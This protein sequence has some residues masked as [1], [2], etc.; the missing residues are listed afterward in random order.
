MNLLRVFS[1]WLLIAWLLGLVSWNGANLQAQAVFQYEISAAEPLILQSLDTLADQSILTAGYLSNSAQEER[2][3]IANWSPCGEMKW[4]RSFSP[5]QSAR[6]LKVLATADGG[7]LICGRVGEEQTHNAWVMKLSSSGTAEWGFSFGGNG[8]DAALSLA[9]S[10]D[11]FWVVGYTTSFGAERQDMLVLNLSKT[12]DWLWAQTIGE[13]SNDIA[14]SLV[15]QADG[16]ALIAGHTR[17]YGSRLA[18]MLIEMQPAGNLIWAKTYGAFHNEWFQEVIPSQ[19]GNLLIAGSST[20]H[21]VGGVD[22]W[23][24]KTNVEG[25]LIWSAVYG[26]ERDENGWALREQADGTIAIVGTIEY[27]GQFQRDLLLLQTTASGQLLSSQSYGSPIESERI[28][29]EVF[30]GFGLNRLGQWWI[31]SG[32]REDNGLNGQSLLLNASSEGNSGGCFQ[33]DLALT[34]STGELDITSQQPQVSSLTSLQVNWAP[35]NWQ[36]TNEAIL[37]EDLCPVKPYELAADTIFCEGDSVIIDATREGVWAYE[38]QDGSE[39]AIRVITAAGR[40]V[41]RWWLDP[42]LNCFQTDTMVVEMR[43]TPQPDLGPDVPMCEGDSVWLTPMAE[44]MYRWQDGST[45]TSLLAVEPGKYSVSVEQNGCVGQDELILQRDFVP[46]RLFEMADSNTCEGTTIELTRPN[47]PGTFTWPDGSGGFVYPVAESGLVQL[48]YKSAICQT[49]T[50]D[51]I[52]VAFRNCE[53]EAFVPTAFSPNQDG[54]NEFWFPQWNCTPLTVRL[55]IF[56]RWGNRV[57]QSTER[58]PL[59]DGSS[60]KGVVQPEGVYL[61]QLEYEFEGQDGRE[62]HTLGGSLQVIR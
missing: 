1:S 11:R 8:Q 45:Q 16:S 62:I 47:I 38:W 27:S 4:S 19:D 7:S 50:T 28:E 30:S 48:A 23:L 39:D 18:G 9:E 34:A 3:L 58:H 52:R 14:T 24:L 36:E 51:S 26:A 31:A 10:S 12:G 55:N 41:I 29:G 61:W 59:W 25:T 22:L 17:S 15:L 33:A 40:Y 43:S 53:C 56:N 35:L 20:T 44:G 5:N 21:G 49:L 32:Q 57:Y 13:A 6:I 42:A 2:P 46:D 54:I 60:D 37:V